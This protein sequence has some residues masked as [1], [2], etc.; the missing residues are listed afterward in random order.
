MRIIKDLQVD[1]SGF[2]RKTRVREESALMTEA[3]SICRDRLIILSPFVEPDED[4]CHGI[5][6]RRSALLIRR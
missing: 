1:N 4:D 3:I 5:R 2:I 6:A